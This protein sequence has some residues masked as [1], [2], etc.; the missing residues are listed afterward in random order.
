MS[1]KERAFSI[2]NGEKVIDEMSKKDVDLL[3]VEDLEIFAKD[4]SEFAQEIVDDFEETRNNMSESP[5]LLEQWEEN[6]GYQS[7]EWQSVV[8]ELDSYEVELDDDDEIIDAS[9]EVDRIVEIWNQGP[10]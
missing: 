8:D 1:K 6:T 7:E 4:L 10:Q 5:G 2:K 9:A 3:T